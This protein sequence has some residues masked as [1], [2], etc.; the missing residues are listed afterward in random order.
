MLYE[1]SPT[2]ILA[3]AECKC[4]VRKQRTTV[5]CTVYPRI[6]RMDWTALQDNSELCIAVALVELHII[7]SIARNYARK[8]GHLQFKTKR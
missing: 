7:F 8:R 2:I 5:P 4:N 1:D 6:R 3:T